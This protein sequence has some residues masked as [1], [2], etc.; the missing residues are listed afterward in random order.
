MATWRVSTDASAM[1]VETGEL[2]RRHGI[3]RACFYRWKSKFGGLNE[4]W[5]SDLADAREKIAQWKQDY[6]EKRPHRSLQYRTPME[7]A[8]Q[9]AAGFYR[10]ELG[11][12][13]SNTGPL[14]PDPPPPYAEGRVGEN[15]NRRKSHYPWTKDGGQITC[16]RAIN[17]APNKCFARA[18]AMTLRQECPSHTNNTD[19]SIFFIAS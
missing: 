5:F 7:F 6:N 4:N 2:C 1:S 19:V 3:T 9:S 11:E 14:P 12:E 13:G 15:K 16:G 10:A 8:A 18:S 17:C